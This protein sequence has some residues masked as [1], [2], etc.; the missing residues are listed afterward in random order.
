MIFLASHGTVDCRYIGQIKTTRSKAGSSVWSNRFIARLLIIRDISRLRMRGMGK[1]G[2]RER[3]EVTGTIET[4]VPIELSYAGNGLSP[5]DCGRQQFM[6][7]SRRLRER[8]RDKSV[9]HITAV[10]K[11]YARQGTHSA[12]T[13]LTASVAI[14]VLSRTACTISAFPVAFVRPSNAISKQAVSIK[15]SRKKEKR[16]INRVAFIYE[17]SITLFF[18]DMSVESYLSRIEKSNKILKTTIE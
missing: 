5:S 9:I 1:R 12:I 8:T 3:A 6:R 13:D 15:T 11:I 17:R 4:L 10:C 16:C 18:K 2:G 7:N 14:R